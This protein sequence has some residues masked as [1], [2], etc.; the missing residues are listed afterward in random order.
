MSHQN[1]PLNALMWNK[2]IFATYIIDKGLIDRIPHNFVFNGKILKQPL[3]QEFIQVLANIVKRSVN[4]LPIS[5]RKII[6]SLQTH[7]SS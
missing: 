4:P 6:T 7:Q 3:N 2:R 1:I 5:K